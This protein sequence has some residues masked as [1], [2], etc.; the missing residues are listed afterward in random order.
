MLLKILSKLG[1]K[2]TVLDRG[3]AN[4]KFNETKTTI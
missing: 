4:P 1:R 2:K 3:P